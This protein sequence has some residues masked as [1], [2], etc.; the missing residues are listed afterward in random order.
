MPITEFFSM[1]SNTDSLPSNKAAPSSSGNSLPSNC[2]SWTVVS[3][4]WEHLVDPYAE[5]SSQAAAPKAEEAFSKEPIQEEPSVAHSKVDDQSDHSDLD[6]P[7]P[8]LPGEG[9]FTH[10]RWCASCYDA[11]NNYSHEQCRK[12]NKMCPRPVKYYI[13]RSQCSYCMLGQH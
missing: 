4:G 1:T 12:G 7:P 2:S 6:V 10:C 11:A 3:E 8:K 9:P 5:S 13:Y